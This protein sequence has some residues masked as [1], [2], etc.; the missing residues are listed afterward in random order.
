VITRLAARLIVEREANRERGTDR[1][2]RLRVFDE[3]TLEL[4][5]GWVMYVG[6]SVADFDETSTGVHSL[7]PVFLV[8]RVTGEL[9]TAGRAWP[10]EKYVE[11]Y[12]TR[13]LAGQ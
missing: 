5:W 7:H 3:L 13:L 12:E 4:P 8:N 6:E 1:I 10:V 2:G 9:L 11:D